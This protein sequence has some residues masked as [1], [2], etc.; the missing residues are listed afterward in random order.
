MNKT[1]MELGDI[2]EDI[3]Q[4]DYKRA[5]LYDVHGENLVPF[6]SKSVPLE[7]RLS[8]IEKRLKSRGTPD[9][10]YQIK[11]K[12]WGN[13][14]VANIYYYS[15]GDPD[16]TLS[17]IEVDKVDKIEVIEKASPTLPN[18]TISFDEHQKVLREKL[19][20]EY[21]VKGLEDEIDKLNQYIEELETEEPESSG[22]LLSD[23]TQKFIS[24]SLEQVMPIVDK[25]LEQRDLKLKLDLL[26]MTN[27]Q[28]AQPQPQI[29]PNGNGMAGGQYDTPPMHLHEDDGA[30]LTEVEE[31]HL[32]GMEM[33]KAQNPELY[34]KTMRD[35]QAYY[36]QNGEE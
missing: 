32:D 22:G 26:K 15:K 2:Q 29:Q 7:K 36:A 28:V 12:H 18:G 3:L 6:N 25:M 11:A 14:A 13:K 19:E 35:L 4:S 16:K 1:L 31:M 8:E 33:L 23:N 24:S 9:G 27:G 34:E 10:L 21:K 30:E 20:L 17:E 5:A